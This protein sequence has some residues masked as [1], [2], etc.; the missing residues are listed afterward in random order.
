M[1]I[2]RCWL[3]REYEKQ[4]VDENIP[5]QKSLALYYITGGKVPSL[6]FQHGSEVVSLAVGDSFCY[7]KYRAQVCSLVVYR[8]NHPLSLG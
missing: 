8:L 5:E 6:S 7:S 1:S 4:I 3:V 2:L